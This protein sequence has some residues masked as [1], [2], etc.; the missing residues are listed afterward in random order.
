M[1]SG[2]RNYVAAGLLTGLAVLTKSIAAFW[3]PVVFLAVYL[4]HHKFRLKDIII[5]SIVLSGTAVPWFLYMFTAYGN[6]F[7]YRHFIFNLRGGTEHGQNSAPLY[8]YLMYM[9]DSWKPFIFMAPIACYTVIKYGLSDFRKILVPVVWACIIFIPYSV[10]SSKV[11]WYIYPLWIP[12]LLCTALTIQ[13]I[14]RRPVLILFSFILIL[15]SLHPY[16][17]FDS[18]YSP[19]LEFFLYSGF[20]FFVYLILERKIPG[21]K[22]NKMPYRFL[23]YSFWGVFIFISGFFGIRQSLDTPDWSRNVKNLAERNQGLRNIAVAGR[24]YESVLFYFNTGNVQAFSRTNS[25]PEYVVSTEA[26][27]TT[28]GKSY[29][30]I[31]MEG[32]LM[33]F[34]L[35]NETVTE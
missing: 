23:V 22:G 19:L 26:I 28:N 20:V 10:A 24:P 12:I 14:A 30:L 9:I 15:F 31:D 8:W 4:S 7:I 3:I 2:Q 18:G 16:W 11:W 1:K 6:E 33:L 29:T 25:V 34:K 35:Q 17:R 27:H 32:D 13:D 5:Y 21:A